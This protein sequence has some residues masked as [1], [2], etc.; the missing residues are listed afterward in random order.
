[1]RVLVGRAAEGGAGECRDEVGDASAAKPPSVSR[2]EASLSKLA[3]SSSCGL[4][5]PRS[6]I[7]AERR[8]AEGLMLL[9]SC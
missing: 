3:C 2:S 7:A 4:A 8:V 9:A 1:M 5:A 6:S